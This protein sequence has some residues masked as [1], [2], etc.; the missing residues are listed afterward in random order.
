MAVGTAERARN[1]RSAIDLR[2]GDEVRLEAEGIGT[3]TNRIAAQEH[4]PP[5]LAPA[6][7]GLRRRGAGTARAAAYN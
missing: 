1:V 6:T 7:P 2:P 4:D 5:P 3:L